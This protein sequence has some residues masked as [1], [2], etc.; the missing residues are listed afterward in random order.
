MRRLGASSPK[1]HRGRPDHGKKRG[2]AI[3]ENDGRILKRF[4]DSKRPLTG[5]PI[6]VFWKHENDN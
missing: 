2:A 5:F 1:S 6:K 4:Q 3:G